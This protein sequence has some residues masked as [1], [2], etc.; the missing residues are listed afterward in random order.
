MRR[1]QGILMPWVKCRL[2]SSLLIILSWHGTVTRYSLSILP[3]HDIKWQHNTQQSRRPI[4]LTFRI[5]RKSGRSYCLIRAKLN[6][7]AHFMF[8]NLTVSYKANIGVFRVISRRHRLFPLSS[9]SSSEL[10]MLYHEIE[11]TFQK[12]YRIVEPSTIISHYYAQYI[13]TDRSFISSRRQLSSH[14]SIVEYN[15]VVIT[16]FITRVLQKIL[17]GLPLLWFAEGRRYWISRGYWYISTFRLRHSLD[18][19]TRQLLAVSLD[20]RDVI[21]SLINITDWAAHASLPP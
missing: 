12:T 2:F 13:I 5:C 11:S 9:I 6:A 10:F 3:A 21:C 19:F 15:F 7:S 1:W 8:I 14:T 20:F 4:K 16:S 17:P 18:I